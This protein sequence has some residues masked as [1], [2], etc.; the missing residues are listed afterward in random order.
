M[1]KFELARKC[2]KCWSQENWGAQ[3][4]SAESGSN[5][6]GYNSTLWESAEFDKVCDK[7][8]DEGCDSYD[9]CAG[10]GE[11]FH[12]S[13]LMTGS[14]TWSS[15]ASSVMGSAIWRGPLI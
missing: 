12:T 9:D 11:S 8:C 4:S 5:L 2:V 3:M 10:N 7:G 13:Q 15:W 14:V 6:T 1:V